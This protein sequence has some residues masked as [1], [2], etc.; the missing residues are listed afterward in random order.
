M[1]FLLLSRYIQVRY[2]RGRSTLNLIIAASI[3]T[4]I[5]FFFPRRT[6][7]IHAEKLPSCISMRLLMH[8]KRMSIRLSTR[9]FV[10][11]VRA[12]NRL[13]VNPSVPRL[14]GRFLVFRM[15]NPS[16]S[17]AFRVDFHL[18]R[19]LMSSNERDKEQEFDEYCMRLFFKFTHPLKD[20]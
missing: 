12:T 9:K 13:A 5:P 18:A 10:T 19:I 3:V 17:V 1:A 4:H 16:N 20:V 6:Q 14:N 8:L 7:P 11:F 15:R 2:S